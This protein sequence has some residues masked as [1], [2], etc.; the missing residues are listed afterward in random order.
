MKFK[1]DGNKRTHQQMRRRRRRRRTEH[2]PG[3]KNLMMRERV[4]LWA[5]N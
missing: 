5:N 2:S 3:Y 1:S 4:K